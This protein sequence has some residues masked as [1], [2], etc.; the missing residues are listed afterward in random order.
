VVLVSSS[1]LWEVPMA[2][3]PPANSTAK[4]LW[5]P[6]CLSQ[7]RHLQDGARITALIPPRLEGNWISTSCEVRPGPE[8][9]TRFYTF[10]PGRLFKALQFYYRDGSCSEPIYTLVVRGKL[11]LRQASWITRGGTEAEHHLLKVGVV[12]H[13]P[14]ALRELSTRLQLS[15]TGLLSRQWAAG[16]VYELFNA[17]AGRDCLAGLGFSMQELGLLRVETQ[18]R[19]H[20]RLVQE[21]FLGDVH[22]DWAQRIQHRP[23][24]YQSPLQSAMHHIHPCAVCGLV[25]RSSEHQPPVLPRPRALALALGGRWVSGQCEARPAVL[26]LTR[27][28]SFHEDHRSWEGRYHHYADPACRQPTFALRAVGHYAWGGPSTTVQGGTELVFKVTWAS[29]TALD[30]ATLRALNDSRPG[31]CGRAGGWVLGEE[32]DVTFTGGCAA[33]GIRLP[34]REYEL[35]KMELDHR[36]RPLLFTGERPTDGS[37]PDR[38]DKRPTS[39]QPPLVQCVAPH[40]PPPPPRYSQHSSPHHHHLPPSTATSSA[41]AQSP[42]LW[43][44]VLGGVSWHLFTAH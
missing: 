4:L 12:L 7:L 18:H 6:Q 5:E 37:S 23:T 21:L 29:V 44:S 32:Q 41:S 19:P 39:Y 31:S 22:T 27:D 36:Q 2:P 20:G 24:G 40:E 33:L 3:Y 30:Q 28:F 13:S 10:Y 1:K 15:C 17:R 8:F 43:L 14:R 16:R 35:F 9:L 42:L 34:H 11:R 38:L 26:F 25:Y